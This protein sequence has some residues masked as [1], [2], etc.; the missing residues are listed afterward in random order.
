MILA[1]RLAAGDPNTG[2]GF[3][4]DVIIATSIG[5]TPFTGGEGS[6]IGTLI[7]SLIMGVIG[8]GLNLMGVHAFYQYIIKGVILFI[9][10]ALDIAIRSGTFKTLL[11]K[12]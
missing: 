5:G 11:G 2:T 9:V 12:S 8:N 3:E 1:P 10:V 7:G 4:F 6:V